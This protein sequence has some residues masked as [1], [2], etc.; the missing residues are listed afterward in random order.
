M[1]VELVIR[2]LIGLVVVLVATLVVALV[3]CQDKV[4][5]QENRIAFLEQR[6]EVSRKAYDTNL[7]AIVKEYDEAMKEM[8]R[9]LNK[10]QSS[11]GK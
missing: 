1:S 3:V 5:K 2:M 4:R 6:L 7:A 8:A 10:F 11:R 9:K